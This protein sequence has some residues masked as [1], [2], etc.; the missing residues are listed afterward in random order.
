[1]RTAGA[2]QPRKGGPPPT[3]PP[4]R[5]IVKTT[6][7]L[8]AAGEYV[9]GE[10]FIEN[11]K[12]SPVPPTSSIRSEV[13]VYNLEDSPVTPGLVAA[14]H[15]LSGEDTTDARAGGPRAA[16]EISP[17]DPA[18]RAVRGHGGPRRA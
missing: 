6:R 9:P 5:Y 14:H 18:V 1:E 10:L 17:E 4:P 11:G 7:L 8:N 13:A 15:A 2:R 12:V 16:A 3:R